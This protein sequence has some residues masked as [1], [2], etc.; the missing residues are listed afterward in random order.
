[1]PS[2]SYGSALWFQFPLEVVSDF[3]TSLPICSSEKP[4]I[5]VSIQLEKHLIKSNT[6]L[7]VKE[8]HIHKLKTKGHFLAVI[9]TFM[10]NM[11]PMS[12][13]MMEG[14]MKT[15]SPRIKTKA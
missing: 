12:Y 2:I 6:F 10:K 5:T 13:M 1:M 7:M 3:M 11:P 4:N 15:S 14:R 8:N 9:K